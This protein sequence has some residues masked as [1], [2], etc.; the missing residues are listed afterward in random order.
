MSNPELAQQRL[1]QRQEFGSTII[2]AFAICQA[3][4]SWLI[5]LKSFLSGVGSSAVTRRWCA[6]L[7]EQHLRHGRTRPQQVQQVSG[8]YFL[9]GGMDPDA[10]PVNVA[11]HHTPDFYINEEGMPFGTRARAHLAIDY[12]LMHSEGQ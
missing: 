7:S 3:T 5:A 12:M 4:Q 2:K 6:L 1:L 8:L 9:T 11:P 10:D